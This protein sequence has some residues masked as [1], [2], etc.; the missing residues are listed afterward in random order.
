[1]RLKVKMA[2]SQQGLTGDSLLL[3]NLFCEEKNYRAKAAK[4]AFYRVLEIVINFRIPI[5]F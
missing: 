1:M 4:N 5:L 3:L 2:E